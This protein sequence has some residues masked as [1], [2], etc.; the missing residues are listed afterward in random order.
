MV[1]RQFPEGMGPARPPSGQGDPDSSW[2]QR[3][4]RW[5]ERGQ[6][7]VLVVVGLALLALAA[8]I[9]VW[10]VVEFFRGIPHLTLGVDTT[11]FLESMLLVLILVEIVHTVV[12]SLR[13]HALSPQPF[14]VVGLVVVIRKII[15]ALGTHSGASTSQLAV[16][17]GLVGVLVASLVALHLFGGARGPAIPLAGGRD[18]KPEGSVEGT[19]D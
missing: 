7:I 17:L 8:V 2:H 3:A 1:A 13:S 6:D 12:L 16:Y 10:G 9:L 11:N 5:T 14:L 18:G 19:V 15:L 4:T